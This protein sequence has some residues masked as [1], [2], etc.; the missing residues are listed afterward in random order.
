VENYTGNKGK[1]KDR[2]GSSCDRVSAIHIK[3]CDASVKSAAFSKIL[4]CFFARRRK[5]IGTWAACG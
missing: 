1:R 5:L 4:A 2:P 3:K